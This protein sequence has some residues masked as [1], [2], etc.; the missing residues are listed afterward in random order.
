[1]G[2]M[3]PTF[4][5]FFT[6]W[7]AGENIPEIT[8]RYFIGGNNKRLLLEH[9]EDYCAAYGGSASAHPACDQVTADAADV[10]VNAAYYLDAIHYA[11]NGTAW[12]LGPDQIE[13]IHFRDRSCGNVLD[14]LPCRILVTRERTHV[15]LH[16][17]PPRAPRVH[18]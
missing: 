18:R 9:D 5:D 8:P 13:W 12:M 3:P 17:P 11:T 15:I 2:E 4:V 16:L 6:R 1:M 7:T 14:P 10:D